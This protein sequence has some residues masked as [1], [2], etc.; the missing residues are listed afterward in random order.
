MVLPDQ[1]NC[2][3]KPIHS[4]RPLRG[5]DVVL[6]RPVGS[7]RALVRR[8][9]NEGAR[10]V[11]L[12]LVSIRPLP[13]SGT[14]QAALAEAEH[15]DAVV[16]ASASAV[17][18]CFRLRPG[19][20]APGLVF[21]QGPAT[22]RA[23]RRYGVEPILPEQGFTSE[24]LL[25]HPFFNSVA[26]KRVVR[27]AGLGGRDLLLDR[28][29]AQGSN[30]SA[31]ALYQ[32]MP[33]RWN[34]HHRQVLEQ[35]SDPILVISSTEGLEILLRLLDTQQRKRLR[36]WRMLVSSARLEA[37]ARAVGFDRVHRAASAAS[38]DLRAGLSTLAKA[39]RGR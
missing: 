39:S 28:L 25:L 36:R 13:S 3:V 5:L 11:N 38:A 1:Q 4:Q 21:A 22:A 23:L 12:P 14:L 17:G 34:R 29:R 9:R 37:A 20:H 27:L 2:G 31:V 24:D 35:F 19:F 30:V 26:G 8:C 18:A 15:A 32:R 7:A 16:F 10:C 6:T 33:A